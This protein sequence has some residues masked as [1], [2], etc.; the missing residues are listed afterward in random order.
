M[1]LKLALLEFD[2]CGQFDANRFQDFSV[3]RELFL[4]QILLDRPTKEAR[5]PWTGN[6]R[7]HLVSLADVADDLLPPPAA[8]ML[9]C[10]EWLVSNEPIGAKLGGI[11]EPIYAKFK[12]TLSDDV[13]YGFPVYTY[14]APPRTQRLHENGPHLPALNCMEA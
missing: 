3:F 11:K 8:P 1:L 7:Q 9:L 10:L 2:S 13:G 12:L 6:R 5:G 14:S 4:K